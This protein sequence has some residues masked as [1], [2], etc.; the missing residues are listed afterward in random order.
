MVSTAFRALQ[1]TLVLSK[2]EEATMLW[3]T[4]SEESFVDVE[5]FYV[6]VASAFNRRIND[7]I[8]HLRRHIEDVE[9]KSWKT[10]KEFD[11]ALDTVVSKM[12]R[13]MET[14]KAKEVEF[15]L[16]RKKKRAAENDDV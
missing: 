1:D 10:P 14:F 6:D 8:D 5:N 3:A 11:A 15:S 13:Y 9:S 16:E 12:T 2:L 4:T 7:V